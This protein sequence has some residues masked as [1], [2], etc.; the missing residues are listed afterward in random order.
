MAPGFPARLSVAAYVHKAELHV[1]GMRECSRLPSYVRM[2]LVSITCQRR[3]PQVA[4][5]ATRQIA[6]PM[7]TIERQL[8]A[9]LL[10]QIVNLQAP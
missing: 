3:G 6:Q 1:A 9:R 7:S 8:N 4:A 2:V 10:R 5:N